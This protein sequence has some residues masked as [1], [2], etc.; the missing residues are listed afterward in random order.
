MSNLTLCRRRVVWIKTLARVTVGTVRRARWRTAGSRRPTTNRH[1]SYCPV[2]A[3]NRTRARDP[4]IRRERPAT[5]RLAGGN[6]PRVPRHWRDR[7]PD[8]AMLARPPWVPAHPRKNSSRAHDTKSR[9]RI[10]S[11]PPLSIW[12]HRPRTP[13]VIIQPTPSFCKLSGSRAFRHV[14]LASLL[15]PLQ[16]TCRTSASDLFIFELRQ[17]LELFRAPR[18][19]DGDRPRSD[20]S[21]ESND[22]DRRFFLPIE[23]ANQVFIIDVL[24]LQG[25]I[26]WHFFSSKAVSVAYF[27]QSSRSRHPPLIHRRN[28]GP[29]SRRLSGG[30]RALVLALQCAFHGTKNIVVVSS[31]VLTDFKNFP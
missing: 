12:K 22:D 29:S 8:R 17:L 23:A 30:G 9:H 31:S 18:D 7:D 27:F 15:L 25:T 2:A 21:S 1:T 16:S 11:S 10:R 20:S 14:V 28:L 26:L 6:R 24:L 19:F 4:R 3:N 5:T 13:F